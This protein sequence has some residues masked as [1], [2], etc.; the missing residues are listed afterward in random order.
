MFKISCPYTCSSIHI[1]WLFY[2]SM[3]ID[4]SLRAYFLTFNIYVFLWLKSMYCRQHTV[5]YCLFNLIW[6][7]LPLIR[8]VVVQLLSCV[9]LFET[10]WTLAH[11]L[12]LSFIISWNPLKLTSVESVI[13]SSNFILS[14]P[15][16][17]SPSIFPASVFCM[18]QFLG[19]VTNYLYYDHCS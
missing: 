4:L 9:Q 14:C 3:S 12:S 2:W 10:P 6:L 8:V 16:L 13:L 15:L 17:L 18:S 19:Y 11:Q 7:P 5:G 1:S